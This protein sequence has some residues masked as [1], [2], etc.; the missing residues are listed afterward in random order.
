MIRNLNQVNFKRFGTISPERGSD[1]R[2][3][4][5][6]YRQT[7][8]LHSGN[9]SVYYSEE[10]R[11]WL[12]CGAG[13]TILSVSEDGQEYMHFY[14]D[15]PVCIFPGIYF[16]LAPLQDTSNAELCSK[17]EPQIAGTR[18]QDS[19]LVVRHQLRVGD[20]YTFF[21]HEKEMGFVFSGES[22][23]MPELTYVDKGTL[24]SVADGTDI[25]LEQGLM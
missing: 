18:K 7:L 16:S 8:E 10:N 9:A 4:G 1:N 20:I 19:N 2:P 25:L 23:S 14:L 13:M 21:Y 17:S 6:A 3:T 22:H 24:H 15:K 11:S 5:M 12:N